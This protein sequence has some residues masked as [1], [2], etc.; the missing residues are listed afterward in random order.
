MARRRQAVSTVL[1]VLALLAGF[2]WWRLRASQGG[3]G[4]DAL[5]PSRT[6]RGRVRVQ[7]PPPPRLEVPRPKAPRGAL[8]VRVGDPKRWHPAITMGWDIPQAEDYWPRRDEVPWPDLPS[9]DA[10]QDLADAAAR[11]DVFDP[12][13]AE[14][15]RHFLDVLPADHV[16]GDDAMVDVDDPWALLHAMEAERVAGITAWFETDAG[17]P[18]D[19]LD[20]LDGARTRAQTLVDRFG[21]DPVADFARLQLL[22]LAAMDLSSNGQAPSIADPEQ[23]AATL[24]DLLDE[25]T[26]P[27]VVEAAAGVAAM[28]EPGALHPDDTVAVIDAAQSRLSDLPPDLRQALARGAL[29]QAFAIDDLDRAADWTDVLATAI[30]TADADPEALDP[31]VDVDAARGQLAARGRGTPATWQAELVAAVWRCH[32]AQPITATTHTTARWDRGWQWSDLT[33]EDAALGTCLA[34]SRWTL[35][36]DVAELALTVAVDVPRPDPPR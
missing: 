22:E 15:L 11:Y 32:D 3:P 2:A 33:P 8:T 17:T 36:P 23:T 25:A 35:E 1:L 21:G 30:P 9:V 26:D 10:L 6:E 27:L 24:Q 16:I 34:G 20:L 5:G 29:A 31:A 28:L 13:F 12:H 4:D 14:A 7:A 19:L 18:R